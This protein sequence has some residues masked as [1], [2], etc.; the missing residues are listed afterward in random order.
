MSNKKA[1]RVRPGWVEY[2]GGHWI[3]AAS[4]VEVGADELPEPPCSDDVHLITRLRAADGQ[5]WRSTH[6]TRVVLDAIAAAEGVPETRDASGDVESERG[7][8]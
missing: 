2:Q 1:P 3:R 6:P 8:R 4:V 5:E 7:G